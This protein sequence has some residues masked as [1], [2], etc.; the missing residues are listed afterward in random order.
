MIT[1]QTTNAYANDG[2]II[3][4]DLT[5]ADIEYSEYEIKQYQTKLLEDKKHIE[6]Y[7]L[8]TLT[9][10]TQEDF[11]QIFK[12][13]L[14]H[15][16]NASSLISKF[17]LN[18]INESAIPSIND[19]RMLAFLNYKNISNG[20]IDIQYSVGIKFAKHINVLSIKDRKRFLYLLTKVANSENE[21]VA[22]ASYALGLSYF[23]ELE[24]S[25]PTNSAK[26]KSLAKTYLAKA[27]EEGV[28]EAALILSRYYRF[29]ENN[30]TEAAKW[31]KL[32]AEGGDDEAKGELALTY[33]SGSGVK[34][35]YKKAL[36]WANEGA[37]ANDP[38]SFTVLG[39][40]YE[41]GWGVTI[42]RK[43]A[44][45][46]Y[47]TGCSLGEKMSCDLYNILYSKTH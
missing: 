5:L 38:A 43:K 13:T 36:F 9:N 14:Q 46:N 23:Y 27:T 33:M 35:D 21:H 30:V 11:E 18:R 37:K 22:N 42:N 40:L 16:Q 19:T 31:A 34:T 41:K 44:L 47:A 7:Y 1:I 24:D 20:N 28:M 29:K 2:P 12:K 3:G 15:D 45:A 6:Q 8:T 25:Y 26:L 10:S 17:Y 39:V 4:D 32:A